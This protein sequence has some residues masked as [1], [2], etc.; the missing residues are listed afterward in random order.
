MFKPCAIKEI[1]NL[2]QADVVRVGGDYIFS[3]GRGAAPVSI[4]FHG[5]SLTV[6]YV[7]SWAGRGRGVNPL[8]NYYVNSTGGLIEKDPYFTSTFWYGWA[9]LR[10]GTSIDIRYTGDNTPIIQYP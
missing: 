6:S 3:Q 8:R 2:V 7:N 5:E 10:R 4:D 1:T 9:I